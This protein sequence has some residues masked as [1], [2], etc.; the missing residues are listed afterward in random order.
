MSLWKDTW[1]F[2]TC[3]CDELPHGSLLFMWLNWRTSE[4]L[5]FNCCSCEL[6]ANWKRSAGFALS[7]AR[8]SGGGRRLTN[9]NSLPKS[10][11]IDT[12]LYMWETCYTSTMVRRE[13]PTININL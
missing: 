11:F 6:S 3:R 7:L 13:H 12:L 9:V 8:Q 2:S 1:E 5:C 4:R 10:R